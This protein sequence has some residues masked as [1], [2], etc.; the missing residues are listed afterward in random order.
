MER[1]DPNALL[2]APTAMGLKTSENATQNNE[3]E[4]FATNAT[5]HQPIGLEARNAPD[6]PALQAASRPTV[7]NPENVKI[8]APHAQAPSQRVPTVMDDPLDDISFEDHELEE[9]DLWEETPDPTPLLEQ[10]E[11]NV[12][13]EKTNPAQAQVESPNTPHSHSATANSPDTQPSPQVDG[14]ERPHPTPERQTINPGRRRQYIRMLATGAL[15]S[16]LPQHEPASPNLTFHGTDANITT[17]RSMEEPIQSGATQAVA[18][19]KCEEG[20]LTP[21]EF[22]DFGKGPEMVQVIKKTGSPSVKVRAKGQNLQM[23]PYIT[24][25]TYFSCPEKDGYYT[26][27]LSQ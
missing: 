25:P 1:P 23:D 9:H 19:F 22:I 17:L 27:N 12:E 16:M 18:I 15:L 8:T 26:Y 11:T 21:H 2:D 24:T 4:G 3:D 10:P 6:A 20:E 14:K 13:D 7:V 5:Q